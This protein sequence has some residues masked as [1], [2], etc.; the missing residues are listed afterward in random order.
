MFGS[1][2]SKSMFNNRQISYADKNIMNPVSNPYGQVKVIN[3]GGGGGGGGGN[4]ITPEEL[5]S[6]EEIEQL[7][8][9]NLAGKTY[10]HIPTNFTQYLKLFDI[11]NN[12]YKKHMS[13]KGL[14]LL[15]QIT[16]EG[17][18]GAMNAYGLNTL[19][20]EL[21]IQNNWY[22]EQIQLIINGINVNPAFDL[23]VGTL[24]MSQTFELAPLF[25]YYIKLYG[26]PAPGAGFDPAKLNI[27]LTALENMGIDPYK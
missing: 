4:V 5:A 22:Q 13:N 18:T 21:E 9:S 11:V 23:N 19:N 3:T 7:Y 20:V 14:A 24:S 16:T 2:S 25:M 8:T 27:V 12:A 15:F 1:F 10:L 17:L 26:T 6:L